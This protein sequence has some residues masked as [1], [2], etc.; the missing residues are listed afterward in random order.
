MNKEGRKMFKKNE[1]LALG[2]RH[3]SY[4][5]KFAPETMLNMQENPLKHTV[6]ANILITKTDRA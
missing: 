1:C 3:M 4:I 6:T 5:T 2:I